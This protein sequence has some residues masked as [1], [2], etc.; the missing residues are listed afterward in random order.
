MTMVLTIL[1]AMM[2]FFA[3][4]P[5]AAYVMSKGN[6]LIYQGA[7]ESL[8]SNQSISKMLI[9]QEATAPVQSEDRVTV[10]AARLGA[11]ECDRISLSAPLYDDDSNDKLI[12]GVGH[13][14]ES[15]LPGGGKPILL[16]GHDTTF[17]APLEQIVIGD[18]V[19]V[20][21]EDKDYY[22]SIVATKVAFTTDTSAYDLSREREQLI[23]YTCYPF[24]Q[25]LGERKERYFV[26]GDPI[27][28]EDALT[29]E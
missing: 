21:M 16:S 4:K 28:A 8:I 13:Y 1:G 26:Y 3:G 5:V 29:N 7:P 18:V 10:S 25:L 15:G 6:L 9:N 12:K 14:P 20:V 24:G 23:L 22:Y 11:I 19:R 27:S 2:L 17:F